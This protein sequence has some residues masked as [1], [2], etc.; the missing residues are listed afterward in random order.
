L[1]HWCVWRSIISV[2]QW[3]GRSESDDR[4]V[5]PSNTKTD[6][7]ALTAGGGE[8]VRANARIVRCE[9]IVWTE[10]DAEQLPCPDGSFDVVR[11]TLTMSCIRTTC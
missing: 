7:I 2:P 9:D 6:G 1:T 4:G 10:G 11:T 8:Q 3:Q 5:E